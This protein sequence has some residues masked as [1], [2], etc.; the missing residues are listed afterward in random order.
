MHELPDQLATL[1]TLLKYADRIN[2]PTQA[3]ELVARAFQEMMSGRRGPVALEMPWDQF[4]ATAEVT[5]RDP[6]PPTPAPTPD[7]EKIAAMAKLLDG[8]KAPMLWVGGG[9]LH[10]AAEIKALAERTG[11]PVVSFR[12]AAG[13]RR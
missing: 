9:A 1:R 2:H 8:A 4:T 7:P 11:A 3:P 6:L 12:A 5:P 10:A 13:N